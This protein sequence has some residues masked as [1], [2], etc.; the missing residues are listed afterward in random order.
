MGW[1]DI[2]KE[3]LKQVVAG[4]GPV[5]NTKDVSEDPRMT[6]AYP[7]LA[8]HSQY[9]SFV[10]RALSEFRTNLGLVDVPEEY[11]NKRGTLWKKV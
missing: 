10:G 9:H 4:L 2:S 6:K 7:D 5:F 11:N 8:R 1:L 3:S